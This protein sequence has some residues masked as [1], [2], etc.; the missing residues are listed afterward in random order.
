M[1]FSETCAAGGTACYDSK[2]W[3]PELCQVGGCS[4]STDAS[5]E[6]FMM[7]LRNKYSNK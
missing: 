3:L 7:F 6:N 5:M 1:H 2:R 4:S